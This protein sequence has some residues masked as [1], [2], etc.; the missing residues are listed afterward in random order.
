[1]SMYSRLARPFS[2]TSSTLWLNT[3]FMTSPGG[4]TNPRKPYARA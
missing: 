3:T 1:M 4:A 2:D